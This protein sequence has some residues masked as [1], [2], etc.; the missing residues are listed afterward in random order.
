MFN[1]P[2]LVNSKYDWQGMKYS[3]NRQLPLG[4]G[5]TVTASV[6]IPKFWVT[7]APGSNGCLGQDYACA[8]AVDFAI[9]LGQ[10][11][12]GS[13]EPTF[14]LHAGFDNRDASFEN[15]GP[16]AYLYVDGP[17][18]D[19]LETPGVWPFSKLGTLLAFGFPGSLPGPM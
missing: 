3:V 13:R 16:F 11:P 8:R 1:D 9:E 17:I 10:G 15:Y 7:G 18:T 4:V 5:V 2:D 19:K 14:R 12:S 6:Y